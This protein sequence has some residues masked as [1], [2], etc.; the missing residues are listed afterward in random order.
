MNRNFE[1]WKEFY[2]L[3][4]LKMFNLVCETNNNELGSPNDTLGSPNNESDNN[5]FGDNIRSPTLTS[6][7]TCTF[8]EF[9]EF[10]YKN[11][12]L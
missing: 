7:L 12:S 8:D 1:S 10:I 11:S 6:R 2:H 4:L 3:H 5:E 9:V